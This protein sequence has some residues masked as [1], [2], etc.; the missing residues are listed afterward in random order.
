MFFPLTSSDDGVQ[1]LFVDGANVL[2][3]R[4]HRKFGPPSCW[5]V[6]DDGQTHELM[7]LDLWSKA[8]AEPG[9]NRLDS[10]QNLKGID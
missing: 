6:S 2:D 8:S 7:E 10:I 3:S 9:N 4:H 1:S 5:A